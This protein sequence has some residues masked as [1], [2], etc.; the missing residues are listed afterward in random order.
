MP[1]RLLLTA[2]LALGLA[3]LLLL[4]P[5]EGFD[6]TGHYSS[7]LQIA[8][9]GQVPHLGDAW[10]AREVEAYQAAGPMPYSPPTLQAGTT[11]RAYF[12]GDPAPRGTAVSPPFGASTLANWQGQHPPL[13]YLLLAPA[14]KAIAGMP[15]RERLYWLRGAS[16]LLA[17]G[18][19]CLAALFNARWLGI[20][21]WQTAL[22]PLLMPSWFPEMARLGNDSLACLLL[23]LAWGAL[24][25]LRRHP[26]DRQGWLLLGSW[27][28]LGLLTKAYV[29]PIALAG[30]GYLAVVS[31]RQRRVLSRG[32]KV[33]PI[34]GFALAIAIGAP[35]Y[36]WLAASGIA[37]TNDADTL[38]QHGGLI[39][40]LAQ[41]WS[42]PDFLYS[43]ASLVKSVIWAGSWS[44]A[45]PPALYY[46]P[47]LAFAAALLALWLWA[48]RHMPAEILPPLV[49]LLPLM[50]GLI[51]QILL[52]LALGAKGVTGG[53]YLHSLVAPLALIVATAAAYLDRT[54]G[55]RA[56]CA[57]M[58][59]YALAFGAAMAW[60]QV[61]M[62]S[63]CNDR[64]ADNPV[65]NV[66]W[67]C[68]LDAGLVWR[69][70]AMLS[71]PGLA[72]ALAVLGLAS[73]AAGLMSVRKRVG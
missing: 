56:A 44:F 47:Y 33:M 31:W 73:L 37:P 55:G 65:Y 15:L 12:Q 34:A 39:A 57:A 27:F 45:R 19:L 69:R 13:Y 54:V 17:F 63:G 29:W 22:W 53:W 16:F 30:F 51:G 23:T 3:H 20:R 18:A 8:D 64:T 48:N 21:D 59:A 1:A 50:L 68:A 52:W 7:I 46:M 9:A 60:L 24:L 5:F 6:E 32:A 38:A 71:E 58:L 62:F 4:P 70:L 11:Y 25:R 40:G 42:M 49:F 2:V 61:G 67:S 72:A 66:D 43:L 36:L 28:G 26:D 41:H 35:W 10:M 14:A